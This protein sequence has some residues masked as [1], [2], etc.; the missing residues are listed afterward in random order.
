MEGIVQRIGWSEWPAAA[1]EI[2]RVFRSPAGEQ[3]VLEDNVFIEGVLPSA[4]LRTLSD[5]EMSAYRA[6]FVTPGEGRRPMLTWPRQIPLG[7]EPQDVCE[8]V[9]AYGA[10]MQTAPFPK[11]FI[12]GNPGT[13]VDDKSVIHP[14]DELIIP[15]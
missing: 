9:D 8:I 10:F 7:D 3:A 13:L 4:I 14:G 11:L 5:E 12:A 6:P 15:E 1:T 2:F